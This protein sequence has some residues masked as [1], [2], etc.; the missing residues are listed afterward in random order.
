MQVSKKTFIYGSWILPDPRLDP[1]LNKTIIAIRSLIIAV[2]ATAASSF[3]GVY[4]VYL[5]ASAVDMG[6]LQ[7]TANSLGNGGQLL[8]G[9]LSDRRGSRKPFLLLGSAILTCLWF[10]MG[11]VRTPLELI[12]VYAGISLFSAMITVNWFSLI[13]DETL[14]TTRGKFLAVINNLSSVGTIISLVV[15]TLFFRGEVTEDVALPF[16]A[17]S[18]SYLISGVMISRLKETNHA[19]KV[20][21]SIRKTLGSLKSHPA[22]YNY[23]VAMNVQGFFWSMAWPMFPITMVLIMHFSLASVAI[24]T[25]ASLIPTIGLQYLLGKITDRIYRPP[26][27]FLNRIMLSAIPLLYAFSTTFPEFMFMEVYSGVVGAIQNVVMN[28]YILD[29]APEK[30]RAEYLSIINGFNGIVYLVGALAGGYLLEALMSS[31]PVYQALLYAY[32][33]VFAGRFASSFLFLR[34]KEPEN[35]GRAPLQLYSLLFRLKPPGS[36][37]GGTI[38]IR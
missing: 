32:L 15:M 28:S 2:G 23:F 38:R 6:W 30:Q 36:P 27:I 10:S 14:S 34:L 5:G 33:I 24:L 17:A 19:T 29:A 18:A 12:A 4:G 3:V 31:L 20:V 9:R 37:S 35:K 22:F 16:F 11:I 21:G 1:M 25:V 7:S 26:L 13:A 8:W